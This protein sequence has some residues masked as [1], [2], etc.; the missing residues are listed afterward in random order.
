MTSLVSIYRRFPNPEA[1][2]VFLES[3][4]WPEGPRCPY[5]GSDKAA[6]KNEGK[7]YTL[8]ASR[9]QCWGCQK[10]YSVTVNTIFHNTHI[11]LQRWFLLISLML[12]AKK[13]LSALQASRDLEMR[14][15][16]VR[17]M[18]MQIREAMGREDQGRLLSGLVK[19]DETFI[20]GKPRKANDRDDDGPGAPRGG[21]G[22]LPVVGAVERGGRVKAKPVPFERLSQPDMLRLAYEWLDKSAA[23]HTDEY[24]GYG[25]MRFR[26]VH[27]RVSH[28]RRYVGSDLF[29][30]QYASFTAS[31][32]NGSAAT[33]MRSL[34]ATITGARRTLLRFCSIMLASLKVHNSGHLDALT[35][36]ICK[37]GGLGLGPW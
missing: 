15:G 17:R 14:Y 2:K 23:V 30:R 1:A 7:G 11:D 32:R 10:S 12:N 36:L 6:Q 29:D 24:A 26:H 27:R 21:S 18:M 22:K 33:S 4:R 19:M 35:S 5:C 8:A 28:A 31:A 25:T 9:W 13:G 20:G 3:V 34:F 16:T 37:Q